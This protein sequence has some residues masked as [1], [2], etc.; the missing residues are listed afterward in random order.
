M[1]VNPE[2][3]E[4]VFTSDCEKVQ[5]PRSHA[6]VSGRRYYNPSQGRFLGR[7]PIEESGGLNLYGFVG[8]NPTNRWD[9]LGMLTILAE[10]L[11]AR[12]MTIDSLRDVDGL[13]LTL[14]GDDVWWGRAMP[15]AHAGT[16]LGDVGLLDY[17]HNPREWLEAYRSGSSWVDGAFAEMSNEIGSAFATM[18]ASALAL[19][20]FRETYGLDGSNAT[21]E[22]GGGGERAAPGLIITYAGI[23]VNRIGFRNFD[24][25]AK[26]VVSFVGAL[27]DAGVRF[28]MLPAGAPRNLQEAVEFWLNA[29][30][31]TAEKVEMI[32]SPTDYMATV[33]SALERLNNTLGRVGPFEAHTT[34][35]FKQLETRPFFVFWTQ[36]T[37]VPYTKTEIVNGPH[38]GLFFSVGSATDEASRVLVER[39][40]SLGGGSGVP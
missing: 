19:R 25:K 22:F 17:L 23:R 20:A 15:G 7:D 1:R 16:E 34:I 8:N 37:W 36:Q 30:Q 35:E 12:G 9:F 39:I 33:S 38:A 4:S 18:E 13:D 31:F 11:E 32:P 29:L 5:I 40:K 28:D 6:K 3:S 10:E 24:S 27:E 2:Y 26:A 21:V 14:L